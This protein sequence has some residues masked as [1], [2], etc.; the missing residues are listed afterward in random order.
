MIY[1]PV[2]MRGVEGRGGVPVVGAVADPGEVAVAEE[3]LVVVH[4]ELGQPG[5]Q[6]VHGHLPQPVTG[7]SG[8]DR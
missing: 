6:L 3:G 4:G 7:Q 2:P 1:E 5:D 8:Q